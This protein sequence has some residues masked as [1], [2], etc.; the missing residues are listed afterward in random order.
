[1]AQKAGVAS[2]P[3]KEVVFQDVE[4]R[5]FQYNFDFAPVSL[6]E[7]HNVLDIIDAFKVH[8][9]PEMWDRMGMTYQTPSEFDIEYHFQN[10]QNKALHRVSTCYLTSLNVVYAQSG[11]SNHDGGYPTQLTIQL[12]FQEIETLTRERIEDFEI[13]RS[14]GKARIQTSDDEQSLGMPSEIRVSE[15]RG[16]DF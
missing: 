16:P 7:Y 2:N 4:K 14:S 3:R 1:M 10:T 5:R 15:N 9:H 11:W 13:G 6:K 8:M 12:E